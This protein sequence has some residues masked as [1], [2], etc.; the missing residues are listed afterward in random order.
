ME[1]CPGIIKVGEVEL[2]TIHNPGHTPGCISFLLED[3]GVKSLLCGDI[4]G[5]SGRLGFINGPG[6][7]L[8]D[9]KKSIKKL[10]EYTPQRLYPGHGTFLMGDA[11]SHLMIYD[12]KMNAPWTSIITS[13]G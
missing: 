10:M 13:V 11:M 4:T 6:F 3:D 1:G 9:W 5:A 2:E 7:V 8:D 12:Q